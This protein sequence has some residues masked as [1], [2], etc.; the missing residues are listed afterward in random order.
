MEPK[1]NSI[2]EIR[3]FFI[4][5]EDNN[6]PLLLMNISIN[7]KRKNAT[8]HLS[9]IYKRTFYLKEYSFFSSTH[10]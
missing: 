2:E 6:T 4:I 1:I 5:A 9:I 8:N 10:C 3:V 7:N